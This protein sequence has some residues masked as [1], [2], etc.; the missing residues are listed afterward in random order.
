MS[1]YWLLKTEPESFSIQDLAKSPKKTTCWDGVR[2]YQAR[3][4][5]R[6]E[7]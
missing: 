3:N 5:L 6:D 2:N 4:Y 1:K 7:M